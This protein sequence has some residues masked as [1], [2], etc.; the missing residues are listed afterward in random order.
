[1][2]SMPRELNHLKMEIKSKMMIC[3][4]VMLSQIRH[5]PEY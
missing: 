4:A 3:Y 5:L 2:I 1:M